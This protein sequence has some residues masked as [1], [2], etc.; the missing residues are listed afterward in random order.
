M[1]KLILV[2]GLLT[3]M[4]TYSEE[5]PAVTEVVSSVVS[6]VVS[7]GK[8]ILKGVK[9]G[10]D[11]GRQDGTSID[12]AL[13]IYNKEQFKQNIKANVLA[14]TKDEIGYKVTVG[15]RN[16]TDQM[17]R[18]TNLNEQS[19]LQLLDIDGF[20]V[21]AQPPFEDIN[22]PKKAS[23]KA[24]FRFPADGKP[25]LIKIYENEINISD[26]VIKINE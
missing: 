23:V 21:F 24:N 11:T 17:V 22:I 14:V 9:E 19:S 15:L 10:V 4:V 2:L 1:K 3:Y 5:K 16:E 20:S 13:I 25:K 12:N 26:E 8:N 7:T 6:G 18:L